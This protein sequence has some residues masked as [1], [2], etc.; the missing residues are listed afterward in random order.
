MVCL[1]VF[2]SSM[3][4]HTI[5]HRRITMLEKIF[6]AWFYITV[7]SLTISALIIAAVAIWFAGWQILMMLLKSPVAIVIGAIVIYIMFVNGKQD[8]EEG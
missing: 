7:I 8:V 5:N 1:G 6:R 2:N 4:N 3:S